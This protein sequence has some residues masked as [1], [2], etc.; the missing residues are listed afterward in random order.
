MMEA[1][2]EEE[3]EEE[4]HLSKEIQEQQKEENPGDGDALKDEDQEEHSVHA[5]SSL[6]PLN[7]IR[8]QGQAGKIA[9]KILID[10]G[11]THCFVDAM[12]AERCDFVIKQTLPL[13]VSVGDGAKVKSMAIFPSFRWN[14][15][16]FTFTAPVR[17]LTLGSC[18]MVLGADWLRSC[19]LVTFDFE[20]LKIIFVKNGKKLELQ[21]LRATGN[22][23]M[24]RKS[25]AT[26]TE[27]TAILC[28]MNSIEVVSQL[29][30]SPEVLSLLDAYE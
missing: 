19:G 1:V 23:E 20:N 18:D 12:V 21:G 16:G 22:K 17:L 24:G 25:K 8:I 4:Q 6:S 11:S 9:L 15:H 30:L 13:L 7:T 14:T 10:S 29:S 26:S 2:E 5:L 28:Q 27:T 3:E